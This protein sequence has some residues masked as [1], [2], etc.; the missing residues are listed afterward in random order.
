MGGA[1]S[2]VT[3][4]TIRMMEYISAVRMPRVKPMVATMISMA[5]PAFMPAP[6]DNASQWPWRL[7]RAPT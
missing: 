2:D 5:P 3:T 6:R 1:I 4:A 7:A